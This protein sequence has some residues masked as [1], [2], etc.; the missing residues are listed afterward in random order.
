MT[1]RL[2]SW[3]T[4]RYCSFDDN[5]MLWSQIAKLSS[6]P[7]RVSLGYNKD[8]TARAAI[9][10]LAGDLHQE[11][12]RRPALPRCDGTKIF[13]RF[14]MIFVRKRGILVESVSATTR[15][16]LLKPPTERS[17]SGKVPDGEIA[18]FSQPRGEYLW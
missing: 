5:D 16:T 1:R 2:Y 18:C 7:T 8:N 10:A 3:R 4:S 15:T 17:M 9:A 11:I 14:R 6:S 12:A 13:Q